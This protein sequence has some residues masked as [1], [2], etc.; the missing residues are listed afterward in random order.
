MPCTAS[1]KLSCSQIQSPPPVPQRWTKSVK[2]EGTRHMFLQ[3]IDFK[4]FKA[5]LAQVFQVTP[6]SRMSSASECPLSALP[7][8]VALAV[9]AVAMALGAHF[10]QSAV[11][12]GRADFFSSGNHAE[13]PN[14]AGYLPQQALQILVFFLLSPLA[15][16]SLALGLVTLKCDKKKLFLLSFVTATALIFAALAVMVLFPD[17]G[18]LWACGYVEC[19]WAPMH[20]K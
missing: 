9:S 12:S 4:P 8:W 10:L 14:A 3:M 16:A 7:S 11:Y 20:S 13:W 19:F 17:S 1:C 5:L 2:K 15:V 6:A 18:D